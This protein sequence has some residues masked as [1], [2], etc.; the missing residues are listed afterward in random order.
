[1]LLSLVI[2]TRNRA[3]SLSKCLDY[4]LGMQWAFEVVVVDNGST[5]STR[6]VINSFQQSCP[7]RI[8]AKTVFEPSAGLARARN[9]GWRAATGE[10]VGFTDDDCYVDPDFM[11]AVSRQFASDASLGYLG[12]RILLFDSRD[13]RK[14]I[15]ESTTT[16]D[17]PPRTFVPAGFIQGAN[18]AFRREALEACGGFDELMGAG[19]AYPAEDIDL[20]T[21]LSAVGWA[22]RYSP[23]PVVYHHH[24]R[25]SADDAFQ[26]DKGY[27]VGRGAYYAACVINIAVPGQ[28]ILYWL[29]NARRYSV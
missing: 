20:I 13:L 10:I 7:E 9:T 17:V 21:R 15:K 29:R 6:D 11:N 24:G 27:D 1:M 16:E 22:G 18:F 25:R 26:L 2:S 28:A 3:E 4:T 23:E 14:T 12:G 19:T 5:D 8:S